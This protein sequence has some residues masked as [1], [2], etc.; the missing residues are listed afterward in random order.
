[1]TCIDNFSAITTSIV[2]TTSIFITTHLN[3]SFWSKLGDQA[4][5]GVIIY[6]IV[7]IS[8]AITTYNIGTNINFEEN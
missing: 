4:F 2:I 3:L 5:I 1:M 8:I 7:T 6:A